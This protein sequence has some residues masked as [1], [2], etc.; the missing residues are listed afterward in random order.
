MI[1]FKTFLYFPNNFLSYHPI[2]L[3][4]SGSYLRPH[5]SGFTICYDSERT[6]SAA[7]N[8]MP[9]Q[10]KAYRKRF[11]EP[12]IVCCDRLQVE[13]SFLLE[14]ISENRS[15]FIAFFMQFT[16]FLARPLK[17][18]VDLRSVVSN[19]VFMATEKVEMQTGSNCRVFTR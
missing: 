7:L 9:K 16:F 17:K 19:G 13:K 5:L 1:T 4:K 12:I 11:Y 14:R 8:S 10:L 15:S 3:R 6:K 18:T 2:F